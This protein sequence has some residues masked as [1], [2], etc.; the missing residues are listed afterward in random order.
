LVVRRRAEWV[1]VE[2]PDWLA[3]HRPDL[4]EKYRPG[5]SNVPGEIAALLE[6]SDP[7]RG[8]NNEDR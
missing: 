5:W 6:Q 4:L 1:A 3:V 7:D 2:R 8:D